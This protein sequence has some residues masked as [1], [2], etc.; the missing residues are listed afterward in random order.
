M[1]SLDSLLCFSSI[2]RGEFSYVKNF[3]KFQKLLFVRKIKLYKYYSLTEFVIWNG[4]PVWGCSSNGRALALHAR[5]TGI[6][7]RRLHPTEEKPLFYT[8]FGPFFPTHNFNKRNA[9]QAIESDDAGNVL[10][11]ILQRKR[12]K[13]EEAH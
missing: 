10:K 1:Q 9:I 7:T 2:N 4:I 12:T 13:K 6:D 8:I 5:G 11:Q 3:S